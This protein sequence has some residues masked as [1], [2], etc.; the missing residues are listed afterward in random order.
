MHIGVYIT[1]NNH[2]VSDPPIPFVFQY[3]FKAKAIKKKKVNLSISVDGV[4]VIMRKK[5]KKVSNNV[6][7]F[8]FFIILYFHKTRYFRS[9]FSAHYML[10]FLSHLFVSSR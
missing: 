6:K 10:N 1:Y 7:P 9:L 3:E 5:K 2:S 4:K 8:S